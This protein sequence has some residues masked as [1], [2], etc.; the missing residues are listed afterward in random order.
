MGIKLNKFSLTLLYTRRLNNVSKDFKPPPPAEL[1]ISDYFMQLKAQWFSSVLFVEIQFQF[2]KGY[3]L[4]IKKKHLE[5]LLFTRLLAKLF[6]L[7]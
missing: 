1:E 3:P 7:P 4:I 5:P 2:V 6:F